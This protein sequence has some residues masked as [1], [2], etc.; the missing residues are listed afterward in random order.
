M[1]VDDLAMI[2]KDP[3]ALIDQ[4]E[5]TPYNFK[6]KGSGP[7]NFHLGCGFKRDS[8][9]TLCMNP[10]KYIDRMEEAYVQ[11][12]GIKPVQKYR[13]PLQKGDHPELETTPFL[14]EKGKEIY[15]S[16]IGSDQWNI[17]IGRFDIQ[18]DQYRSIAFRY[19]KATIQSWTQHL[20]LT[21]TNIII[22][23]VTC[24]F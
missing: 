13:S 24:R 16:L 19:R 18:S 4:L 9:G 20:F 3:Q 23:S 5:S 17:S 21:M 6:L 11:H 1:Y 15:Q 12:F 14:D 8:T 22:I 10:G 7:L 2:L